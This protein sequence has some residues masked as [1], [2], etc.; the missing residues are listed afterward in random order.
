MVLITAGALVIGLLI[1][2]YAFMT[3]PGAAP[4]ELQAPQFPTP[5]ALA[6]GRALG[7]T[8]APVTVQIWSDFQCPSCKRFSEQVEPPLV[9]SYVAPGIARFEYNDLAFLGR[10]SGYDESV[11]A[12]AAARCADDQGRFWQMHDW[13]FANWAGENEGAFNPERLR[14]IAEMAGLDLD[15]YDACMATGEQ[16]SAAR[17]QTAEGFALGINSTPTL[18]INGERYDGQISAAAIGQAIEAAAGDATPA[19]PS[20][21]S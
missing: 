4:A 7:S 2:G 16:Q 17:S 10:G 19:P 14:A 21:G 6:D 3:R 9:T 18:V 1:V 13:L 12:A 8:A 20:Q 11:E 15:A 5:V